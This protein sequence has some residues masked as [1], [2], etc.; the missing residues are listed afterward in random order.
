MQVPAPLDEIT[1]ADFLRERDMVL[2]RVRM[3]RGEPGCDRVHTLGSRCSD[4]AREPR[5][6]ARQVAERQVQRSFRIEQHARRAHQDA[7]HRKRRDRAGRQ[8]AGVA[9]AA[10]T[11]GV[12]AVDQ[13]HMRAALAQYIS[14]RG[15]DDAG[16]DDGDRR[17]GPYGRSGVAHAKMRGRLVKRTARRKPAHKSRIL[18]LPPSPRASQCDI[19]W[20]LHPTRG[21]RRPAGGGQAP[22]RLLAE[23]PE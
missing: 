17:R 18:I 10:S 2:D 9:I 12:R 16:T 19:S 3:Q 22:P 11:T 14:G 20:L 8:R 4:E 6:C 5:Q 23:R 21:K 13:R 7:R 15:T 1:R